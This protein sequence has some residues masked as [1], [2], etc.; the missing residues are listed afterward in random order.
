MKKIFLMAFAALMFSFAANA[1]V[2]DLT[3][4]QV[5]KMTLERPMV[6]DFYAN[7]CDPCR[8]FSPIYEKAAKEYGDAI[9][10]YRMD[11]DT[12]AKYFSELGGSAIPFI[13][14]IYPDSEGKWEVVKHTGFMEASVLVEY[15]NGTLDMWN[16]Q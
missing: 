12:D 6:I 11:V 14:F 16:A 15:L 9:D 8:A 10:F 1:Q 3:D 4:S 2:K 13:V 5:A 7:W